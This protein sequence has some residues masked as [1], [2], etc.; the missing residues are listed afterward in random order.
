MRGGVM[1]IPIARLAARSGWLCLHGRSRRD[2]TAAELAVPE[3]AGAT[4]LGCGLPR[5][6]GYGQCRMG[7]GRTSVAQSPSPQAPDLTSSQAPGCQR[8]RDIGQRTTNANGRCMYL[9]MAL[10][11]VAPR[12]VALLSVTAPTTVHAHATHIYLGCRNLLWIGCDVL[13]LR[14]LV[15]RTARRSSTSSRAVGPV[16]SRS[17]SY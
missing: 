11:C 6:N 3:I 8:G 4:V 10:P 9:G 5:R 1:P 17:Y 13:I 7:T 12:L 2:H 15:G 14:T 16:R